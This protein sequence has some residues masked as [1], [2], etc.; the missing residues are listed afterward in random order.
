MALQRASSTDKHDASR[1]LYDS[2]PVF[3]N[4]ILPT[5]PLRRTVISCFD[6]VSTTDSLDGDL[7]LITRPICI[8]ELCQ[9]TLHSS[10]YL[11]RLTRIL[12]V[13][14]YSV[15][16]PNRSRSCRTFSLATFKRDFVCSGYRISHTGLSTRKT[17]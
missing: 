14:Y 12:P 11:R 9:V 10:F 4:N 16:Y 7:S 1:I 3:T 8:V 5:G 6:Y 17:A 2:Q 13:G 15:I